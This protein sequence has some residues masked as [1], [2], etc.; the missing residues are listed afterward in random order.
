MHLPAGAQGARRPLE[1][2]ELI[3]LK[4]EFLGNISHE[5]RT[6]LHVIIG[7]TDALLDEPLGAEPTQLLQSIRAESEHLYTLLRDLMTLS[8][9][10]TGRI[11][12]ELGSV[13]FT[14]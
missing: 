13:N 14:G 12:V 5:L 10:N 11:N 9:L 7:Y 6:P 4:E 3:R 8:G 2:E 1:R